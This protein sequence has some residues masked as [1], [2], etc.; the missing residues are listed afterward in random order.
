[1]QTVRGVGIGLRR[2][3][4]EALFTSD[5]PE[6]RWVEIHP[7]N[8]VSRGGYF[9]T[10]LERAAERWPIV[11]HGLTLGV[12]AVEPPEAGYTRP[13]R[14]LLH[15]LQVPWHSEHL[16]F[17]GTDGVMLHDLLPLPFDE[18]AIDTACAR[19]RELRDSLELP[20]AIENISFY[21]HLGTP[22]MSELQF[23]LEVLERSDAKLL[24][25]VNNVYVNAK[26][27]GFDPRKYISSIPR[28]RVVQIHVAGH[29]TRPD[30]LVIDTHGD[31]VRQ[32][33]YDLLEHT[34]RHAGEVPVLLERDQNIPSWEQLHAELRRLDEIYQRAT[35]VSWA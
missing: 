2:A 21:A 13:L 22:R 24:L 14:A 10:M 4:A 17:S 26:N 19:I 27:H 11:T 30:G 3:L 35:G 31:A 33:V 16:C 15:E 34:L 29:F 28:E 23:L 5:A 18:Q 8:Y 32:E 12:G 25:D 6:V 1:M 20:V 9:R 7:E